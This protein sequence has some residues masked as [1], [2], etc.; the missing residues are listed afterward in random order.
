MQLVDRA[1]PDFCR[2]R[3][4]EARVISQLIGDDRDLAMLLAFAVDHQLPKTVQGDIE[5]AVAAIS[6]GLRM[7][8]KARGERLL[9]EGTAGL[10]R[11]LEQ[12]WQSA[13]HLRKAGG[14]ERQPATDAEAPEAN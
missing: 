13:Q 3:R 5:R 2:A 10:C 8:A 4:E 1:W 9:A 14:A 12:Y 11:R 6:P 7:Q